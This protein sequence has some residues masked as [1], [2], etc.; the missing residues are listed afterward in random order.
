MEG[1]ARPGARVHAVCADVAAPGGLDPTALAF[2]IDLG[3]C[4][5][6]CCPLSEEGCDPRCPALRE[7]ILEV[8]LG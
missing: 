7:W 1:P 6:G 2:V 4:P 5:G 8:S 3:V